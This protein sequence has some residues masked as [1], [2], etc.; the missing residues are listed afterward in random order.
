LHHADALHH[1]VPQQ[2]LEWKIFSSRGRIGSLML[3]ELPAASDVKSNAKIVWKNPFI[4]PPD[5]VVAYG[6][7]H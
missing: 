6:A 1:L 4:V 3:V 5:D 7:W 2:A